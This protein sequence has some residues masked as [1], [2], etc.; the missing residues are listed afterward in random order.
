MMDSHNARCDHNDPGGYDDDNASSS[1]VSATSL[2]FER[3][4][5]RLAHPDKF[6]PRDDEDPTEGEEAGMS[7]SDDPETGLFLPRRGERGEK[8]HGNDGDDGGDRH[9]HRL[10]GDRWSAAPMPIDRN[11]RRLL[12]VLCALLAA[13]W[14]G[15]LFV[16]TSSQPFRSSSQNGGTGHGIDSQAGKNPGMSI[17]NGAPASENTK[18]KIALDQILDG[19]W[20]PESHSVSW[21]AGPDG[22]DALLLEEGATGRDYLVVD[23]VRAR[24]ATSVAVK[25]VASAA[26]ASSRTLMKKGTF[27][28]HGQ[29][30]Q[31]AATYP[32]RDLQRV[33]LATDQKSNWRYSTTAVYWIFHVAS[34]T[35]EPLIPSEPAARVQLA[36]W[37]PMS[38]GVV[39]TWDNNMFLRRIDSESV[40]QITVDGGP[41]V[42]NGVPDWVYEEEVLAGASA[43]W[44]SSDGSYVAFLHTNETGVPEYPVEYFISRPSGTDAKPGEESYPEVRQ[45]KYPK[46]GGHNPVVNLRFYDVK[47]GEVFS[48]D[49]SG[50][51]ADEDRLINAV[52]WAGEQ[53]LVKETNRVCDVMRA[54]LID[55][56]SRKGST[57]R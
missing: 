47:K 29:P 30:H 17:H 42:F 2:V 45:I 9:R 49:I 33:L 18:R 5:E 10:S 28:Y 55:V 34:Q 1:S 43:T 37:S 31:P 8:R 36:Q 26:V 22:E 39:F 13:T 7:P 23:D 38:D 15:G 20:Y 12:L 44:W 3:I 51:F 53:V 54:V 40:V 32:S 41:E 16:Y 25:G 57:L 35:A 46:A 4:G 11:W 21:I 50:G 24:D 14:L 6:G 56:A 19:F 48:V 27:Q 52:L